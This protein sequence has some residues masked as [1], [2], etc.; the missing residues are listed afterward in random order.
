MLF[1]CYFI[2]FHHLD[3]FIDKELY[4]LALEVQYLKFLLN[5]KFNLVNS[6]KY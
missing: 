6:I 5:I 1:L 2:S 3:L 4:I